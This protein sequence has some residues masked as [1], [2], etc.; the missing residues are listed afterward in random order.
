LIGGMSLTPSAAS[1]APPHRRSAS[2][3]Q[4]PLDRAGDAVHGHHDHYADRATISIAG[5]DIRKAFDLSP[6]QMGYIFSAFAWSYV[7]AQLPGGWLLD[8]FG[9]KTTYLAGLTLWS[10]F[11]MFQGAVGSSRRRGR[12]GAVRAAPRACAAE[13]PSFPGNGRITSAWFPANERG[14]ASAIFNSAQYFA[15]ALFAP[16]WAGSCTRSAGSPCST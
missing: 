5:A 11:T 4:G 9:S 13:A 1:P 16:S 6:V 7:I 8:R 10:L 2:G 12:G 15:T 3:H 14:L